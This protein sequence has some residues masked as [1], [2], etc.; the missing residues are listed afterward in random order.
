MPVSLKQ[1]GIF[2]LRQKIISKNRTVRKCYEHF[3]PRKSLCMY[4]SHVK[5]ITELK[6]CNAQDQEK[7]KED[8]SRD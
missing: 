1:K 6:T 2:Y 5:I 7:I 8:L 3:N 4:L